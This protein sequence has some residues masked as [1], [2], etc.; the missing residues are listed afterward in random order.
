[1]AVVFINGTMAP[2]TMDSGSK[3]KLKALVSTLGL[4]ADSMKAS[5]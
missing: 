4:M 3:I 5:G 2:A 1:M